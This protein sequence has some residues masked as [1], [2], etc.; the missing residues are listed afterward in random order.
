LRK[1]KRQRSREREIKEGDKNITYFFDVTNHRKRKKAISCLEHNGEIFED[2]PSMLEHAKGFYKALFG[3]DL[4]KNI[5][6]DHDFWN[7]EDKVRMEKNEMLEADFSE[8]EIKKAIWDSYAEGAP[9]PDGF[10]FI[11]YQKFWSVIKI[12]FMEL[13]KGFGKG[14]INITRLNYA[15]ITLIPKEEEAKTLKKFRPIS[16]VNCSFKFFTKALNNRL[17]LICDR[18]LAYNQTTFVKGR[19]I[20]ES[21]VAA[22]EIIHDATKKK[23]K[24]IVLKLDYEK[25]YDKMN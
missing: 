6:L 25:T 12:D 13:V 11:F 7:E 4:R 3:S 21:V 8:E 16:L 14:E 9:R 15:I 18:L 5:R 1:L 24:G 19:F 2:A 22:H 17:E 10:S 20:L 23:K